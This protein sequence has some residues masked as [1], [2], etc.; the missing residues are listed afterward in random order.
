MSNKFKPMSRSRSM[1]RSI[2]EM[3]VSKSRKLRGGHLGGHGSS[4]PSGLAAGSTNPVING[5]TIYRLAEKTGQKPAGALYY[6]HQGH[7]VYFKDWSKTL[8][9]MWQ[10]AGYIKNSVRY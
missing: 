1:R 3:R 2:R 8:K 6:V 9:Q 7:H 10:D 4:G 5:H